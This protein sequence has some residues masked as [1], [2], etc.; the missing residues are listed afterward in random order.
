MNPTRRSVLGGLA[1]TITASAGC[2]GRADS[3]DGAGDDGSGDDGDRDSVPVLTVHTVSEHA[4]T[5]DSEHTSDLDAWGRFVASRDI[6]EAYWS[7]AE[8][9]GAEAV[10][11]FVEDTA[12]DDG[13]RLLYLQAYGP[14]TCYDLALE[15]D[16]E[17]GE[18]GLPQVRASIGRTAPEDEPCG[19]A[20]TTVRLLLRLSFDPEAG[21]ADVVEVTVTEDEG[22][23]EE[24]LLEARR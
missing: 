22:E 24:L 16:P 3:E 4:V 9:T 1:A 13:D 14:Q 23:S 20:I 7:D 17:I 15:A 5:P 6:A 19:D 8:G 21:T 11:T 2:L 10:R 12:F 18:N